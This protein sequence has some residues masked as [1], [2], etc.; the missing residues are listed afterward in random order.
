MWT[1]LINQGSPTVECEKD[2]VRFKAVTKKP[3]QGKVYVKGEFGNPKCIKIFGGGE[4]QLRQRGFPSSSSSSSTSSSMGG[5]DM[6]GIEEGG[7][8]YVGGILYYNL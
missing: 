2:V 4:Q 5:G 7:V 6:N 3:F 8:I 1:N